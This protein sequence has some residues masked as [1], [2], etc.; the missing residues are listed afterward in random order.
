MD[1][2]TME[3]D[4]ESQISFA[5]NKYGGN[6]PKSLVR[7]EAER[8][9]TEAMKKYNP[10]SGNVKTYL[11]SRLQKL[12][13]QAYKASTPLNIPES[14]LM[15]RAKLRDFIEFHKETHGFSPTISEIS[16]GLKI[17]EKEAARMLSEYGA[18]RAES[19][20]AGSKDKPMSLSHSSMI[21]SLSPEVRSLATDIY[22]HEK[23]D[24]EI[25]KIHGLK[26]TTYLG[27][28]RAIVSGLRDL[29]SHNIERE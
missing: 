21:M 26:R 27:K 22:V 7:A 18:V 12:S 3:A 5:V 1:N 11:S 17:K 6:R 13:R 9:A 23:K 16:L 28:K 15:G 19:L 10:A 20:F 14:R 25:M 2:P 29:N 24:A 8:L 4:I